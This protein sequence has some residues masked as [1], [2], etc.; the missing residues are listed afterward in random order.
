MLR[1]QLANFGGDILQ[2]NFARA[3]LPQ[4]RDKLIAVVGLDGFGVDLDAGAQYGQQ[5]A[6]G[7]PYYFS[8]LVNL[9]STETITSPFQVGLTTPGNPVFV[10]F[11]AGSSAGTVNLSI[12]ADPTN[13]VSLQ[14]GTT[15]L[16]AGSFN[17]IFSNPYSVEGQVN[18]SAYADGNSIPSSTPSSWQLSF[19]DSGN[20]AYNSLQLNG[21]GG[22]GSVS[23]GALSLD[24]IRVATDFSDVASPTAVPEP[25]CLGLT[26]LATGLLL[27]RRRAQAR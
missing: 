23:S 10:Q 6:T 25:T 27:R 4:L 14:T 18:L 17:A 22:H 12:A 13:T 5:G 15:Y 16:I 8:Y 3:F 24:E 2:R 11:A 1:Q 21:F 20:A 9:S 26:C 19:T 7:V